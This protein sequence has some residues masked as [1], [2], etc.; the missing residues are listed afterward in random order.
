ME[1]N[2]ALLERMLANTYTTS[3][4]Y[5]RLLVLEDMLQHSLFEKKADSADREK[6]LYSQYQTPSERSSAEGVAAW[7]KEV[8]DAFNKEN[9]NAQM[10]SLKNS[11][12][13]LPR[14]VVYAPVTF[15]AKHTE[16]IGSWCRKNIEGRLLL[17][18]RIDP[19]SAGG[20][21]FVWH[22]TLHDFSLRYF[23]KK[24]EPEFKKL[25]AEHGLAL[26]V[27]ADERMSAH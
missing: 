17:D 8:F 10:Q 1:N 11:I 7:G 3:E 24:R 4:I 14:L 15:E 13:E 27:E 22:D 5:K 9:L 18:L 2:I 25:I 21:M 12:E 20:C 23:L 26:L 16:E 19:Q 6:H